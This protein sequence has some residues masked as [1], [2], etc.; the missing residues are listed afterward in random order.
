M[1]YIEAS[2]VVN[3]QDLGK[4]LK[5]IAY[6]AQEARL[7]VMRV[8]HDKGTGHW[9]GAASAADVVN[10]L[11]YQRLSIDVQNPDKEDRDRFILSK[12]HASTLLYAT[13]GERG[14]FPIEE[15]STF[16]DLNSRL[17]GHPCMHA[18]PGVDMST[19]ALGHGIS[20][21]LGMALASQ[22][23]K[24]DFWTY[25]MV[26]E[27][28]L[29][30]GQS[31]EGIMAAAKFAPKRFVLLVDYNK[32]QLDGTSKDIMPLD[33]LAD[34]FSAFN[35]IVA[36]KIFDG[37]DMEAIHESFN[38]VDSASKQGE[39]KGPFV[40]IYDTHKGKGV[41]HMEDDNKWHGSPVDDNNFAIAES[42][43]EATLTA[44]GAT[45]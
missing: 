3:E 6:K 24:K 18:T 14:Y 44:L 41:K 23:S 1:K 32:V 22:Y 40:I 25:V 21:G 5:M 39:A 9:G 37:H 12:G 15:L 19:G 33:P 10:Y 16:R 20:V 7:N 45:L 30:E 27:G 8:L 31:W 13:L 26:G 29:N 11:Y 2:Q 35:W 4:K 42:E 43:L 28:C 17:Q 38:W 34:K 36:P